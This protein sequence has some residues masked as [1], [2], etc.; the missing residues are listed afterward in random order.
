MSF[1]IT[2]RAVFSHSGF[3][4]ALIPVRG[5]QALLP[6]R[7][8]QLTHFLSLAPMKNNV[9]H[10]KVFQQQ[11]VGTFFYRDILANMQ[12]S[13]IVWLISTFPVNT[14]RLGDK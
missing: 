8:T 13:R 11:R 9:I 7:G 4:Q 5:T 1:H 10:V 6:V 12:L 3:P 14:H 2:I